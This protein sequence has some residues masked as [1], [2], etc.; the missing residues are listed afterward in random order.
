MQPPIDH[1]DM[2]ANRQE[3]GIRTGDW[4][5]TILPAVCVL[6]VAGIIST[7]FIPWERHALEII[8]PFGDT[9]FGDFFVTAARYGGNGFYQAIIPALLLFYAWRAGNRLMMCRMR[10]ALY[11]LVTSGLIANVFKFLVGKARP[12]E[13]L[14]NWATLPFSIANDFHSFPS[15]H[16]TTSFALAY[17]FTAFYPR[18]GPV[19]FITA[20]L[21]GTG[22]I[23]GE[24]HF[25]SD[26][27]GGALLGMVTGWA[28]LRFCKHGHDE[29]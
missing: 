17:V 13:N 16:T 12:G 3:T 18:L 11:A 7:L 1:E 2:I 19:F 14:S 25:P 27:M 4:S 29:R 23:V 20:S 22:R 26:V 8:Q 5:D 10:I 21:I 28:M 24:S 6:L 15:G 9:P